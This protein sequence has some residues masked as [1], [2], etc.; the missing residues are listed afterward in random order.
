[1]TAYETGVEALPEVKYQRRPYLVVTR[2]SAR[3]KDVYGSIDD[4]VVRQAQL[5]RGDLE[6]DTAVVAMHP[7]GAPGYLPAFSHLARTGLHVVACATR[8]SVGDAG[9]QMENAL[10]D[11]AAC[12]SDVK[13]RLG[14][15]RVILV[16]WSGGGSLMAGYQAEAEHRT[17]TATAAGE[18]TPLTDTE[19]IAADG[20]ILMAAHRSRH[21]L[22]TDFL[23]PSI[24]DEDRPQIRDP[25]LNIYDPRNPH[26]A[27]FSPEYLAQYRAAQRERN[28]RITNRALE[29]LDAMK[30]SGRPDD[31]HC[32]VVQGTM[33]DPR[34]VDPTVDPN[35]RRPGWSYLGDPRIAND[36]PAGLARFTTT[37]AWL[38]Q[39]SLE[40]A[41]VDAVDAAERI[42]VPTLV[43]VNTADDACPDSHPRDFFDRLPGQNKELHNIVGANHYF[44]GQGE[45]R[46]H[47]DTVARHVHEW[48]RKYG[49]LKHG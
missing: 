46:G 26:K 23:D 32:F 4:A 36:G 29:R 38:S 3:R 25:E 6:S 16:G 45:Q 10:L 20:L 30:T 13:N 27:P 12:I 11:L 1:M 24:R 42:T 37:R 15:E 5:L 33:A 35:D 41:Q 44:S 43:T 7:I 14:Y 39:W 28:A 22:L 9:L 8:Y 34:W 47:L 48:G 17:I 49:L 21:H 2:E 31:E 40:R 18:P 19:L